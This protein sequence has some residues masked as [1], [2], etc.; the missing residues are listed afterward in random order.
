[1]AGPRLNTGLVQFLQLRFFLFQAEIG[2]TLLLPLAGLIPRKGADLQ[3]EGHQGGGRV[4]SGYSRVAI[5]QPLTIHYH[6]SQLTTAWAEP[7]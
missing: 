4:H 7:G 1:M 3:D 6:G 5:P 2:E